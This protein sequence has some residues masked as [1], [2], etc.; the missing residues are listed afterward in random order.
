[1]NDKQKLINYLNI[2]NE[3]DIKNPKS[4]YTKF[5]YTTLSGRDG[6][7]WVKKLEKIPTFIKYITEAKATNK[8]KNQWRVDIPSYDYLKDCKIYKTWKGCTFNLVR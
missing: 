5:P 1:M 4:V 6:T 2:I 3:Y 8:P 7:I